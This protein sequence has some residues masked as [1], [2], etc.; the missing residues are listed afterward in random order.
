M[1][2]WFKAIEHRSNRPMLIKKATS[3]LVAALVSMAAFAADSSNPAEVGSEAYR[4]IPSPPSFRIEATAIEGPVFANASG[5]TLYKWPQHRLRNGYSGEA[6]STP[7]C[8]DEVLTVTAGLMSPYPPGIKLPEIDLRPSCTDLWIPELAENGAEKIGKWSVVERRDGTQQWAFDEQPLYT[9]V[10]D[11][12]PGDVLGGT[13]RRFGGDSPAKRVPIK[14]PPLLPPG[15][16]IASTSIGRMLATSKNQSVYSYVN[17]TANASTCFEECLSVWN[18]V[19]APALTRPQG[20][21]SVLE[22][23]PGVRQWVFRGKPL[24]TYQLDQGS[25]SQEGSDREGWQ[26]VFTQ[27]APRPPASFTQQET[28]QGYVLADNAG[29]TIYRYNCGEDSADQLS[30][31]HPDDTQV[32]RLAMCGGGDPQKCLNFWP[33]VMADATEKSPNRLWTIVTVDPNTGRFAPET[34]ENSIRVWAYRDRPVYLYAGDKKPGDVNGG[35][36]G[37]WRGQR[38]GIRAFWLRDDYMRGIL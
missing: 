21:W 33:Y 24:Y 12:L 1:K 35:G 18:P 31:E 17:D 29:R 15:F 11:S 4:E 36:T 8:Y 7:E 32:Y 19:L 28:L 9:S 2:S 3:G 10:R 25:W 37:E 13:S 20:E 14:P 27:L 38:N 6:P 16:A 34:Q 22:R 26:N 5:K 23:S 30:C